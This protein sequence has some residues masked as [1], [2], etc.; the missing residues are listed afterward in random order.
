MHW[1]CININPILYKMPEKTR[2][3]NF[4]YFQRKMMTW[5]TLD[6]KIFLF[7]HEFRDHQYLNVCIEQTSGYI[8][9]KFLAK[10]QCMCGWV[11]L[12]SFLL[13][14]IKDSHWTHWDMSYLLRTIEISVLLLNSTTQ[15]RSRITTSEASELCE[16]K[17]AKH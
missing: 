10:F 12:F 15:Q 1:L 2:T 7:R 8:L 17:M 4:I 11:F 13:A 5:L 3:S 16:T 9:V 6:F 14:E